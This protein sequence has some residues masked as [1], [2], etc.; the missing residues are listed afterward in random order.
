[1]LLASATIQTPSTNDKEIAMQTRK[2]PRT[3]NEAFGPYASGPIDDPDTGTPLADAIVLA[4]SAAALI[5]LI[6]FALIGWL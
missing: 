3:L 6:V 1:V 5:A 2:Y 4:S